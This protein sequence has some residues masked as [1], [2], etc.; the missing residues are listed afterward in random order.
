MIAIRLIYHSFGQIDDQRVTLDA[1]I[2]V[3]HFEID[4][5]LF[6]VGDGARC[7]EVAAEDGRIS[8]LWE[9]FG[10]D[11]LEDLIVHEF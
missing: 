5:L 3:E 4:G 10:E 2:A 11:I 7:V 8:L 9:L 1:A 6:S